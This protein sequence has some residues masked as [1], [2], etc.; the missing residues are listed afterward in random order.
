MSRRECVLGTWA[1][2]VG[3]PP[4]HS[5]CDWQFDCCSFTVDEAACDG[6]AATRVCRVCSAGSDRIVGVRL[7]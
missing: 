7:A 6:A 2:P 5:P 4:G 3:P 1:G